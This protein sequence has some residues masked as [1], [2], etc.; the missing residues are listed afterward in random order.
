[1]VKKPT[2]LLYIY[3]YVHIDRLWLDEECNFF[4]KKS[5]IQKF[6]CTVSPFVPITKCSYKTMHEK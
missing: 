2:N 4:N 1:M 6:Y 5:W 3:I